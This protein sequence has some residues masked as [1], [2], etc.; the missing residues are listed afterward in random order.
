V[1]ELVRLVGIL[2][3]W[4]CYD[5]SLGDTI[6]VA[7]PTQ[8]KEIFERLKRDFPIELFSAHFHD[9]FGVA[10]ANSMAALESGVVSFDSSAGGLGGCPYAKGASG[11][12]ATEDLIHFFHSMG[13]E[14]GIDP[15]KLAKA[16]EFILQKIGKES[17]SKCHQYYVKQA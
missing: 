11:N 4:G 9:T 17:L 8:V 1:D 7:R 12:V 10:V 3:D 6:G 15:V 5:I 14:T 2:K 16:S 13:I